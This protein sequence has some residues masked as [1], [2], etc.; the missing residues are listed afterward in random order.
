MQQH[1]VSRASLLGLA[2]LSVA[3]SRHSGDGA[4]HTSSVGV[5]SLQAPVDVPSA[6]SRV[7]D[8][9]C[10]HIMSCATGGTPPFGSQSECFEQV[11]GSLAEN[12]N[13][14]TCADGL[15]PVQ[16]AACLTVIHDLSCR[17]PRQSDEPIDQ[18]SAG[19]LCARR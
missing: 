7:A 3:C 1:V 19:A 11:R 15:Q 13:S 14:A 18:C 4:R 2:L 17:E 6:L 9:L 5:T 8:A 12:V 16:L 10:E